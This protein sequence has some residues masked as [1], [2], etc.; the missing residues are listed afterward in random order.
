MFGDDY[1]L[2]QSSRDSSGPLDILLVCNAPFDA[3]FRSY[4]VEPLQA[5]LDYRRQQVT[6]EVG[7]IEVLLPLFR[8]SPVN[9]VDLTDSGEFT[10]PGEKESEKF[11][12]HCSGNSSSTQD[13]L[14]T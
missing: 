14:D 12:A 5:N 7:V 8:E 13:R 4:T 6:L 10:L 1:C 11:A 2:I 9:G 3:I